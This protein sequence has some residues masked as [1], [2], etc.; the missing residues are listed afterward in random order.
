MLCSC[1]SPIITGE[2]TSRRSSNSNSI[3]SDDDEDE[4]ELEGSGYLHPSLFAPPRPKPAAVQAQ[5]SSRVSLPP[6][7]SPMAEGLTV[8]KRMTVDEDQNDMEESGYLHPS[9]FAPPHPAHS[10]PLSK[11]K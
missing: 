7:P 1:S 8:Q 6:P 5:V 4:N 3:Q 9:L 11:H 2:I 10:Q